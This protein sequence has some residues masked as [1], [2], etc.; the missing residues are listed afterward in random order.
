MIHFRKFLKCRQ[1]QLTLDMFLVKKARK[2]TAEEEESTASKRQRMGKMPKGE[3][4]SLF[5][6]G[7]TISKQKPFPHLSLPFHPRMLTHH[8]QKGM[9]TNKV[10]IRLIIIFYYFV[11]A[12]HINMFHKYT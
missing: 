9:Q 8:N 2:A 1:T 3:L 10:K 6:G 11:Y 5:M 12:L 7:D 4:A